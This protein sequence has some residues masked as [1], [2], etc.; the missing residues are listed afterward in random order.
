MSQPGQRR[1]HCFLREPFSIDCMIPVVFRLGRFTKQRLSSAPIADTRKRD[2]PAGEVLVSITRAKLYRQ[3]SLEFH[4]DSETSTGIL[5]RGHLHGLR[6]AFAYELAAERTPDKS[7][8]GPTR[9]RK[10]EHDKS[11]FGTPQFGRGRRG[12]ES[13]DLEPIELSSGGLTN[14]VVA[15]GR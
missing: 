11:L 10:L 13:S 5:K 2:L 8:S 3:A 15:A 9:T 4:R 6:H 7:H 14:A 12:D 1:C